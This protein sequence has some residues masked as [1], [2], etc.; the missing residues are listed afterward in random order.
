MIAHTGTLKFVRSKASKTTTLVVNGDSKKESDE[1]FYLDLYGNSTN[2]LVT[3]SR[4]IGTILS[5]D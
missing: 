3:K 4:G 5:D 1:S 2:S